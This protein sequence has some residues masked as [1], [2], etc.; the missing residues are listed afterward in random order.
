MDDTWVGTPL[1]GDPDAGGPA[2]NFGCDS[3]ATIQGG[4]DG[5]ATGGTVPVGR[6]HLT[7]PRC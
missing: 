6:R 2:T 5:V 4:V 1:N 7:S 3:F